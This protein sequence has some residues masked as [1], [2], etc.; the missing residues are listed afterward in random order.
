MLYSQHFATGSHPVQPSPYACSVFGHVKWFSFQIPGLRYCIHLHTSR[1][2]EAEARSRYSDKATG[3]TV[4]GSQPVRAKIFLSCATSRPALRAHPDSY[5]K[6]TVVLSPGVK[7]SGHADNHSPP[8]SSKVK[9][10]WSCISIPPIC[11]HGVDRK[12]LPLSKLSYSHHHSYA[13]F[14]SPFS[15]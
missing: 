13:T 11:L 7:R 9:N 2:W 1:L 12:K 6:G 3:W 10:G 4:R 5:S 14:I 8:T 15:Y